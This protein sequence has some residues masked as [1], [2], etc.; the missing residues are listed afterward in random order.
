MQRSLQCFRLDTEQG[1]G[2][3][4]SFDKQALTALQRQAPGLMNTSTT[5]RLNGL[6]G[7]MICQKAQSAST[8]SS[9][10]PECIADQSALCQHD[11]IVAREAL[12]QSG[13]IVIGGG[14]A[15]LTA[16]QPF[17]RKRD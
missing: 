14:I 12:N 1:H 3:R 4:S 5:D 16:Q 8:R 11:P 15:G 13:V 2:L 10:K 17:Y 9:R 7:L 6:Q